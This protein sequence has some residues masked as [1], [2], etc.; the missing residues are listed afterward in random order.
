MR[1]CHWMTAPF[2][3]EVLHVA[4]S[5]YY[6]TYVH[7]KLKS[8]QYAERMNNKCHNPGNHALRN[9]DY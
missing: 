9:N 2:Y 8:K 1:F 6:A 5:I 7:V 4:F 3:Y